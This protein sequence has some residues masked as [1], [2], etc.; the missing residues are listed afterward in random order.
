MAGVL[1]VRFAEKME[2]DRILRVAGDAYHVTTRGTAWLE[3][4]LHI[5][6]SALAARRRPMAL[7]CLDLTERRPHLAGALGAAILDRFLAMRWAA[8]MR[9]SR[10]LRITVQGR[11]A[12]AEL[13]LP[14]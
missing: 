10:A 14:S 4:V 8:R 13:G 1:A 9:D 11:T 7:R 6:L 5:D 2:R 3:E 12:L